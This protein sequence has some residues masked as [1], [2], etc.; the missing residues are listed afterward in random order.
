MPISDE[1]REALENETR[2]PFAG[3]DPEREAV[4]RGLPSQPDRPLTGEEEEAEQHDAGRSERVYA[5]AS[6]RVPKE[7]APGDDKLIHGER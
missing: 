3:E 4:E 5:P 1:G 2:P 6:A 7:P